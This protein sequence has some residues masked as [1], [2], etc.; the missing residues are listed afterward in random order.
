M[1]ADVRGELTSSVEAVARGLGPYDRHNYT[2]GP[3]KRDAEG[4]KADWQSEQLLAY[5]YQVGGLLPSLRGGALPALIVRHTHG[6]GT[7]AWTRGVTIHGLGVHVKYPVQFHHWHP[8]CK[9]M[10]V[11]SCA[12]LSVTATRPSFAARTNRSRGAASW[13]RAGGGS[14]VGEAATGRASAAAARRGSASG[15]AGGSASGGASDA[16]IRQI[17]SE[18]ERID[19]AVENL[20]EERQRK[21]DELE[22]LRAEERAGGVGGGARQRTRTR[23]GAR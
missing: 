9:K 23:G 14:A 5:H 12:R 16:K 4:K 8:T 19:V 18:I 2:G 20:S 22:A 3:P 15:G 7:G 17:E 11:R 21:S 1:R 10:L 13:T 6:S